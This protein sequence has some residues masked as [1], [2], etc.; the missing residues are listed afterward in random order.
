LN[1]II[2]IH[3]EIVLVGGG[4]SHAIALK[5]FGMKP[6]EGVRLTLVSEAADSPYSG[7][8]P[9]YVAGFYQRQD[10]HI[11]LRSL[12]QFANAQFYQDRVVGIDFENQRVICA[13]RPPVAFDYLSLDIG[14]VPQKLDFDN[15][16]SIPAKPIS[17]FLDRWQQFLADLAE[18]PDKLAIAIAGG[19]VGGVELAISIHQRLSNLF[20]KTKLDFHLFH[21]GTE[22]LSAHNAQVRRLVTK[23]LERRKIQ[24]HLEEEVI[25]LEE[26][27][28]KCRSGKTWE[29][30]RLFWVTPATAPNWLK[31]SGLQ[32]DSQGFVLVK[33]TLQS[34]SHSQVFATG[35]IATN[36]Q[37]P[38]PKAGVF[39]VRQGKP[40]FENL[41]RIAAQ[42]PLHEYIPQSKFLSLI[43][44]ANGEAIASWGIVGWRSTLMWQW[45]DWIDR[46]FMAKF[47]D[48][49]PMDVTAPMFCAGCGSKVGS[50]T[51]SAV[52]ARLPKVDKE[53]VLIGLNEADDACAIQIPLGQ[54]L[55]QS[56]DYFPGFLNDP[57][58]VAQI[59]AQHCLNDLYA[60][61]ATP[62][63]A[64]AIATVPHGT[65]KA[66]SETLFQLLAGATEV[67]NAA[68][69]PLIG[70]HSTVGKELTF[71]LSCNGYADPNKLLRKSGI[72]VGDVLILTKPLGTGAILAAA[73][74]N[75]CEK[76]WLE[77]AINSML[78]SNQ[79]AIAIFQ[80]HQIHTC[81]D[82]SGFGLVGHLGEMVNASQVSAEIILSQ[83]PMLPGAIAIQKMGIFSS[84]Y[85]QNLQAEKL[86]SFSSS[87]SQNLLYSLLFDPQTSGG[88]LGAVP[89]DRAVD[90]LAKLREQ[91]Y[92]QAQTIGV[93]MESRKVAIEIG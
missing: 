71:G 38:R 35:D 1:K 26:S 64:L 5:M 21:R 28:V 48:F 78:Q 79:L 41:G 75:K 86:V 18:H 60:M 24:V 33:N 61:A 80:S 45:K 11:N 68:R 84:L 32:V 72:Q 14:S 29:C 27:S 3:T 50:N 67:L 83:V 85:A 31:E 20:P 4:H 74:Q 87:Q 47:T 46:R 82:I 17:Q 59:A 92:I 15:P 89:S 55:V 7:M 62:H 77:R 6:I 44:T 58:L 22:L 8:L 90:C 66:E 34:I 49:P 91:G 43:G 52:L 65:P 19:G 57:Y 36:P 37:H 63:S 2:P 23:E 53:G 12:A 30:D 40:L 88:L 9:G 56:L 81:T 39:A 10:C 93:A 69:S 51:L 13:S 25:G 42:L 73:M 70:G 16:Y 54:V 76:E